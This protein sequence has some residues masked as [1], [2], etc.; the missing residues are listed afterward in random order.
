MATRSEFFETLE[1]ANTK[2]ALNRLFRLYVEIFYKKKFK[3]IQINESHK[4]SFILFA[5]K[6]VKK[7]LEMGDSALDS[8]Y[9]DVFT[10]AIASDWENSEKLITDLETYVLPGTFYKVEKGILA[11]EA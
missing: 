1:I 2:K 8:N 7:A 10:M 4:G 9:R 5:Q 3:G 11:E 6:L